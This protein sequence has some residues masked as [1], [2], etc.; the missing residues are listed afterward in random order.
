MSRA[1][2]DHMR[3]ASVATLLV[4]PAGTV[5]F[6]TPTAAELLGLDAADLGHPVSDIVPRV[7]TT[8]YAQLVEPDTERVRRVTTHDGAP[9]DL[10]VTATDDGGRA[11]FLASAIESPP[12]AVAEE[13]WALLDTVM[14]STRDAVL[15]TTAEPIDGP[16]PLIVW[17]N[18]ALEE[19]TGYRLEELIGRSPRILQGPGTDLTVTH[20]VHDALTRWD[21]ATVEVLN[22]RKDGSP[23]WVEFDV[24][25]VANAAGW[26]THWVSV[27][28]D[29]TA[30]RAAQEQR[31]EQQRLVQTILDSLPAQTAMIDRDGWIL[32]VNRPWHEVWHDGSTAPEPEWSS[33]NYLEVCR[34]SAEPRLDSHDDPGGP[35]AYAGILRVLC[36]EAPRFG[37]DYC[38]EVRGELRW[39]HLQAA[40]LTG[41]D[42][43]V[44]THTDITAR[45]DAESELTHQATHDALTGL[46]NRQLLI[47]RLEA[48]LAE[49]RARRERT[50][51]AFLDLDNF[52]DVNDAFGHGYGD[53]VLDTVGA[54][55]QA[56]VR[57]QDVV[58]R[59]GG[60]EYVIVLAGLPESWDAEEYFTRLREV[61][62]RPIEL[63]VASIRP[64]MSVGIVTS[65]P[66]HGD[67]EAVLRDAD[68]AMY[69]SKRGGRDRWTLFSREVRENALTRAVTEDRLATALHHDY[70]EL[71]FQPI[72][73]L[74]QGITVGSEALLRLRTPEGDLLLPDQFLSAVE[75]GP[76]AADVGRWV[77]DRA[78]AQQARWA[79]VSPLHSMSVNVSPRQLGHGRLPGEVRELLATHGVEPHKLVLE[80]TEDMLV[81]A[82]GRGTVELA[83]IRELGVRL[84]VDDFGTGFSALSYLATMPVDVLKIDRSFVTGSGTPRGEALLAAVGSMATV[85]DAVAVCEGIETV[86]ELNRVRS[87]GFVR[88]QGYLLGR[89]AAPGS[90][91]ADPLPVALAELDQ[92]ELAGPER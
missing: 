32:A 20:G 61:V 46:P 5:T 11:W 2:L 52:K 92:P 79:T 25:P 88:G 64:S 10:V 15:V 16:G 82:S 83:E 13:G 76:L 34:M 57:R 78:L 67:A 3:R 14:S 8:A 40:P 65:P 84:A 58:S 71:H 54:R 24:V 38:C 35:E 44:V 73:D 70:F 7:L 49:G 47:R 72:V 51:V 39:F 77:L 36:G 9:I 50:A 37:M 30:R 45:K 53:R 23:F 56:A 69:A 80:V 33:I 26:F 66:H 1:V 6:M 59:V 19:H 68:T 86:E 22:Y 63:G 42:G 17:G 43:A 27:Q 87:L 60:D 41:R 29:T 12:D 75:N 89:P 55:L 28:R 85:V 81:E 62:S 91:P 90:G 18:R 48:T 4:D 21:P 31:D 74:V